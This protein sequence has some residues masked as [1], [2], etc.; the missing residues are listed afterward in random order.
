[1]LVMTCIPQFP[2]EG[3]RAQHT[4]T[5]GIEAKAVSHQTH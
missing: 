3:L 4:S 5:R 1:M 2:N